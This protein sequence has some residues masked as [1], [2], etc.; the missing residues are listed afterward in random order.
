ME[1]EDRGTKRPSDGAAPQD[2]R[3][4]LQEQLSAFSKLLASSQQAVQQIQA[5]LKSLDERYAAL[6]ARVRQLEAGQPAAGAAAKAFDQPSFAEIARRKPQARGRGWAAAAAGPDSAEALPPPAEAPQTKRTVIDLDALADPGPDDVPRAVAAAP[7]TVAVRLVA[8]T[9]HAMDGWAD[10]AYRDLVYLCSRAR[11][12]APGA[13]EQ[14]AARCRQLGSSG[15]VKLVRDQLR[16]LTGQK[17]GWRVDFVGVCAAAG[18]GS[19]VGTPFSRLWFRVPG[20]G[21][22]RAKL[23][24]AQSVTIDSVNGVRLELDAV[25]GNASRAAHA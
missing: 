21:D 2:S 16:R 9:V 8:D 25:P 1:I 3:A 19:G 23:Q 5:T 20:H 24:E 15:L 12:N 11:R 7:P 10:G 14:R 18:T 22:L 17:D 13:A 4:D 6:E